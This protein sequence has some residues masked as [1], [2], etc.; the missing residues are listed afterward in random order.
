MS[1]NNTQKLSE[2]RKIGMVRGRAFSVAYGDA[3][4]CGGGGFRRKPERVHTTARAGAKRKSPHLAA[5][6]F[7]PNHFYTTYWSA[8]NSFCIH[9]MKISSS[10]NQSFSRCVKL[11]PP[12]SKRI[13]ALLTPNSF[14][15]TRLLFLRNIDKQY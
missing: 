5:K 4:P 3:S 6:D 8:V 14:D 15:N 9:Y 2:I 12:D 7:R 1:S 13:D 11:L 10:A